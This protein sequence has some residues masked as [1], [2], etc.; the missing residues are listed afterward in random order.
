MKKGWKKQFK[1]LLVILMAIVVF[2]YL[3]FKLSPW[4]SALL[5]RSEFDK[6]GIAANQS[7]QKYVPDRLASRLN[8][9]YDRKD[10]D[11]LMDI[12]Y[13]EQ[14][15]SHKYP[16]IVWIHGGGLISGSKE[17]VANYC[18]IIA[19]H[20]YAVAAINY[21]V[22]PEAKYP[23]PLRQ[24]QAALHFL[25][26]NEGK[27]P[28]DTTRFVLAGDSGGA[29][30]AAAVA[31]TICKPAYATATRVTARLRSNQLK[32]MV[33]LCGIYDLHKLNLTGTFGS[34]LRT[35]LWSYFGKKEISGDDYAKTASILDYVD[36][37]FPPCFIS[38]GNADPLLSQSL[39][40]ANKLA[41]YGVP[42]DTLFFSKHQTP[43]LAHEYQFNLD[44]RDGQKALAQSLTFLHRY[45][46]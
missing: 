1:Y 33:L 39:H 13:P 24:T 37:S 14:Y 7:L 6:G 4:P 18:K 43:P 11:A 16:I 34:F 42:V 8:Q 22:A 21:T 23:T 2:V 9:R 44:T 28:I 26:A 30:I 31:G 36:N 32:G 5:I 46:Q 17:Q 20:G 27:L 40:L 19:G 35:V 10:S 25:A 3:A 12:Y 41:G 38:A 45:L 29:M 15:G